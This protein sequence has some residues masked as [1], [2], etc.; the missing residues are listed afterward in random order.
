M[1][2]KQIPLI[3][4]LLGCPGC[5][6]STTRAG[7]FHLL[8]LAGVNCEEVTEFAK[9][10]T[11]EGR[12]MALSC[13]PYVFGKQLRNMERLFG[14]VDVIITDSPIILSRYYAKKYMA[15]AYH[16]SFLDFVTEQSKRM[17]GLAY[18]L[19]RVKPYSPIGRNQTESESDQLGN[20][21]KDML[22]EIGYEYKMIDGDE[23]APALIA[24]EVLEMISQ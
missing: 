9:D 7:A 17:G 15:D 2:I 12:K 10:L 18:Y 19:K 20:E 16:P 8:K 14:Q 1:S 11:W 4:S 3:I 23:Q 22:D 5:G 6:K 24:K 13:Q 21:L